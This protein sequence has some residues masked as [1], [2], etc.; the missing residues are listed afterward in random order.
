MI[1]KNNNNKFLNRIDEIKIF[2][3][4]KKKVVNKNKI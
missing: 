2:P 4:F 1:I 3:V